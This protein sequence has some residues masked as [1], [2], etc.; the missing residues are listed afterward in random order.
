MLSVGDTVIAKHDLSDGD[1]KTQHARGYGDIP[2]GTVLMVNEVM[3]NLY[4]TWINVKYDGWTYSVRES[5]L[6]K[7]QKHETF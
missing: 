4:G 6:I 5:D 7:E 2:K 3:T 1:W